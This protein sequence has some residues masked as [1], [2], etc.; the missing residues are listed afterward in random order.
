MNSWFWPRLRDARLSRRTFIGGSA[1][2]W[3]SP[4]HRVV[5][6]EPRFGMPMGLLGR[7]PGD[8]C[9]IRHGYACENT[10]FN[11]GWWHTGEN[12]Y[13]NEGNS[14]GALVYSVADGDV[15]YAD[16]DYPGRVVI[17]RHRDHLFS[18]YGH[19][20][21]DL[22][23]G[24]GDVVARGQILGTVLFRTDARSPSHLH[25]ELRTFLTTPI[26]NGPAPRYA[27]ACGPNCP[28]GPGYWPMGD[29]DH[30]STLGWLNPIHVIADRAF[31]GE[32][33]AGAEIVTSALQE[34]EAVD[35]W[36]LPGDLPDAIR[37]GQLPLVP[38]KRFPLLAIAGGDEATTGT[39]AEAYR[40]WYQIELPDGV[41]S[42]VPGLRASPET[43]GVD[44]RPSA[45][46]FDFLVASGPDGDS[47]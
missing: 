8:G 47:V 36:T 31:E 27:F 5:A 4:A 43:T 33:P 14:A 35:V 37:L 20:D 16:A 29:P 39:S 17:V 2:A 44:G 18:M 23:V 7:N 32:S 6:A 21:Y 42:W 46:R 9:Y 25:F 22:A 45:V 34:I 26:V 28:P 19:L 3:L 30:P 13:V 11:T 24:V 10:G 40:L 12:W 38:R 41:H 1:I 15:V